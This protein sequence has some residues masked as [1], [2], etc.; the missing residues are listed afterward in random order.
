MLGSH[1][2]AL[3]EPTS[4][5]SGAGDA[6]RSCHVLDPTGTVWRNES[7][8]YRARIYQDAIKGNRAVRGDVLKMIAKREGHYRFGAETG[9]GSYRPSASGGLRIE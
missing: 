2:P 4:N 8:A 9:A 7:G 5:S 6:L 3:Q 1:R